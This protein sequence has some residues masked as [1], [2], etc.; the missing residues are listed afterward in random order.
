MTIVSRDYIIGLKEKRRNELKLEY[1]SSGDCIHIGKIS[2]GCNTCFLR[3]NLT[4]FAVYTG[5]ECNTSCGYCYYDKNRNDNTSNSF[6]TIKNKLADFYALTLDNNCN[7]TEISYNSWGETL[8]Y[9]HVIKEASFILKR[10]QEAS[11]R[12]VYS[13]LYTN[14][15]FADNNMLNFL[16]DCEVTELRF[17]H[18]ASG[19]SSS[20][21][22]NMKNAILKGFIVSVEEPSL[23]ENKKK[24]LEM[25]PIYNELG[26]HHLNIV[27][28]QV[29]QFNKPYL[30]K[31]YPTGRIYRDFLWHLYDEGMVY[32]IMEEV[33]NNNY[34]F[35]IIDCNSRVECCRGTNQI[36]L[37]PGLIDWSCMSSSL[38]EI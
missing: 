37:I 11:G 25:L 23:L 6:D 21:L 4:S 22:E 7:L 35:S 13:H 31:K 16:K 18:S 27:E 20:V 8:K 28:C 5:C 29:T 9:P 32:D 38:R 36:S 26:L 10:Y 33:L 34:K 14:G 12:K 17:H 30:E 19:F 15:V 3:N 2:R 24:L 1:S